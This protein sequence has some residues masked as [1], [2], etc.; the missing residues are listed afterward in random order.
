MK[1]FVM[2]DAHTLPD[3]D[4]HQEKEA[5]QGK[6]ECVI[7]NCK[8]L[9]DIKEQAGDADYIG[10]VYQKI[11]AEVLDLMPKLK[12]IVRYGIGYDVVDVAECSKRGIAVCNIPT[13]CIEDVATHAA[14]LLLD[15]T[16][17]VSMYDRQIKDG[18]WDVGYGYANHR[19]SVQTLGFIGF[20]HIAQKFAGY[21]QAF[22][23]KVIAYDP[24]L[25]E[26]VFNKFN[27][28][29]VTLDELLASSDVITLHCAC[30][31]ETRHL[32]NQ[33]TLSKL[34]DGVILINTSRGALI[35]NAALLEGLQNGKILA[36]GLDVNEDEP[37]TDKHH[38]LLA[39]ENLI[40][41]PHSAY[42]SVE[43]SD[44][45]HKDAAQTVLN[46]EAGSLPFNTVNKQQL[47]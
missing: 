30:T 47:I 11:T 36:C 22:G 17:K 21:M 16:R 1:K 32:I 28:C 4:F 27:A 14:A 26:E 41:T 20:G 34:K 46:V 40:I 23:M 12:L 39:F 31:D 35:D 42:N 29:K 25:K 18:N 10:L 38:P 33:K 15:V 44:E 24:Y 13:Y 43:A 7:A 45:Q 3:A 5:L 6:V 8:S 9:Q 37:I 2:L 19:L